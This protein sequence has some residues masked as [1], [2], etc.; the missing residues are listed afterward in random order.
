MSFP[1]LL[2]RG[3]GK[4]ALFS[5]Q[6]KINASFTIFL[7][8]TGKFPV[9][10]YYNFPV[11][12]IVANTI[13]VSAFLG[14]IF[15]GACVHLIFFISWFN[16]PCTMATEFGKYLRTSFYVNPGHD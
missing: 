6:Y 3:S 1:V 11:S 13:W 14:Y 10:Y 8:V 12:T 9:W 5:Y 2:L 16:C 7:D 4:I 15:I